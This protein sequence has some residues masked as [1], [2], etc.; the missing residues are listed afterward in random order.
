MIAVGVLSDR[1]LTSR[2][3]VALEKHHGPTTGGRQYIRAPRLL[4]EQVSYRCGTKRVASGEPA[5]AW[6]RSQACRKRI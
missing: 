6:L 5:T 2:I 4:A 3:R 1:L